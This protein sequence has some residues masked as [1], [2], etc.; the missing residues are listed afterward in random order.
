MK[1]RETSGSLPSTVNTVDALT[2]ASDIPEHTPS[3]LHSRDG[4]FCYAVRGPQFWRFWNPKLSKFS[5]NLAHW[6][7]SQASALR[8]QEHAV[9]LRVTPDSD[10]PVTLPY[11]IAHS[12]PRMWTCA[13]CGKENLDTNYC[14]GCGEPY[15]PE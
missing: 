9:Q 3:L 2:W 11:R 5:T 10:L 1:R 8:G 14:I 15:N 13:H 7:G 6:S 4:K 12:V